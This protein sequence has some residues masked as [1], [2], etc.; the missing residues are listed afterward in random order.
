MTI[1]QLLTATGPVVV[2]TQAQNRNGV[3]V[4]RPF[5]VELEELNHPLSHLSGGLSYT[6]E[7][8]SLVLME[9]GIT[10]SMQ[11]NNPV[12]VMLHSD[13]YITPG[14]SPF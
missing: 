10:K 5:Q 12:L 8:T 1:T 7:N 6:Q 11:S 13:S 9:K 3:L 14:I 2:S 4:H